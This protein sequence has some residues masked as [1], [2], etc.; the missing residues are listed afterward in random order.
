[1]WDDF[2]GM[3]PWLSELALLQ[4]EHPRFPSAQVEA[5][6]IL[7][8]FSTLYYM[9]SANP[10][11]E[12]WRLRIETL[13][14][15][16]PDLNFKCQAASNLVLYY[17][18]FGTIADQRRIVQYIA[19]FRDHPAATP[20]SRIL[21]RH[22]MACPDW[23]SGDNDRAMTLC[24]EGLQIAEQ[25]G[26]HVLDLFLLAYQVYA[27]GCRR[28]DTAAMG[29]ILERM[30]ACLIPQRRLDAAHFHHLMGWY[31]S[32]RHR[33][34]EALIECREAAVVAQISVTS[35]AAFVYI[36]TAQVL[37]LTGRPDESEAYLAKAEAIIER[38]GCLLARY[39][40]SFVRAALALQRDSEQERARAVRSTLELAI[41]LGYRSYTFPHPR[42]LQALCAYA[43]HKG[44]ESD[45]AVS[46]IRRNGLLPPADAPA[47]WPYPV[48]ITTLGR[49]RIE[50]DGK[51]LVFSG[52]VQKKPLELL[53]ALITFGGTDV[54]EDRITEALWSDA[55]GDSA[56][57]SFETALYRIR[58]LIG[59]NVIRLQNGLVTLDR[60]C[61]RVDAWDFSRMAREATGV[62]EANAGARTSAAGPRPEVPQQAERALHLYQGHFL[63]SDA[64]EPWSLS[65]RER[66]KSDY[67]G[68]VTA[69]GR[70]WEAAGEWERAIV[71][72]RKGLET[73]ELAE[74]FYQHLIFCHLKLGQRV[75]AES[76]Y[77][78][79]RTVLSH[80]LGL[81]PSAR[82]E[83]LYASLR[84]QR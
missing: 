61:C 74:E 41:R 83:E 39:E 54:P 26:M 70:W 23:M 81:A 24:E 34:D 8:A 71:C 42:I 11:I 53:K 12:R 80:A 7:G 10:L 19:A 17:L 63:P 3:K 79:C 16:L 51:P 57:R 73:E 64:N 58:K 69:L 65:L 15:E 84:S 77:R 4:Q 56:H 18:W 82:T 29:P 55:D 32:L 49:F 76:V 47:A 67:I 35:P 13:M 44:I 62:L 31:L 33:Y 50:K 21:V 43:L 75:Q 38:H 66:L 36:N 40:N 30:R 1:L 5:R 78:R 28:A 68:L 59:D 27:H 2:S 22:A 14:H 60:Q 52:K 25:S 45:Y 6:V 46:M 20:F 37:L 9:D 48:R 72:F